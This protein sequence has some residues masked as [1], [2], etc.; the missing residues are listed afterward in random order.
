MKEIQQESVKLWELQ[1]ALAPVD[2]AES[3]N[4]SVFLHAKQLTYRKRTSLGHVGGRFL[5]ITTKI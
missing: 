1:I 3:S 5:N 4:K 2:I